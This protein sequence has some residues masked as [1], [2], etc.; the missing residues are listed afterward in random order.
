VTLPVYQ[1]FFRI[2]AGA[3]H[4]E[5]NARY[6]CDRDCHLVG[7][8]PHM[9]LRGKSFA[10]HAEFP[11]GTKQTLL[12]VPRFDFNWQSIYRPLE[13]IPAPKGTRIH[14]VGVFDN[15]KDN[16]NNP[17]PTRDVTWGDQ[18]WQEMMIGWLDVAYDIKK[19]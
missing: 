18:T 17:D 2:P 8:M 13:P 19:K 14:C 12:S 15:S 4:H 6:T 7:Y 3:A 16:P 11:D 9:H 1:V 10:Y 5:V